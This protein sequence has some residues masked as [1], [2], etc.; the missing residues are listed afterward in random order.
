MAGPIN[1]TSV[2]AYTGTILVCLAVLVWV[3][4]L[5]RAD[6]GVPFSFEDDAP[7]FAMLTKGLIDNGWVLHNPFVGMPTGLDLHDFPLTDTVHFV[8]LK[9]IAAGARQFATTLNLY[10]VLTFPLTAVA[11]LAA[12]RSFDV[13]FGPAIVGSLLFA[14]LPYHLIRGEIHIF[15]SAYYLVPLMTMVILW[16]CLGEPLSVGGRAGGDGRRVP[17]RRRAMAGLAICALLASA[18]V[19]YAFFGAAL[20]L[21]GGAFAA[22][23]RRR[24]RLFLPAGVLAGIILLVSVI[25]LAPTL[26]Y[27]SR[28][29]TNPVVARREPE[30][31]ELYGLRIAQLLL[32]ITGHREPHL[33]ALKE[34]YNRR[35]RHVQE[36]ENDSPALGTIGGIGFLLLLWGLLGGP[37]HD[38]RRELFT[39]LGALTISAVLLA[40]TSGFGSL[41]AFLVTP[42]IRAY[43]RMSV[44]IAF[45]SLFAVVI[46]LDRLGRRCSRSRAGRCLFHASLALIVVMGILDQ[47]G[48]GSVPPYRRLKAEFARDADFIG[49]IEAAVPEGAM[50][51]QLPYMAFPEAPPE[52][53]M[54]GYSHL[55]AYLHSKTLR[56]SYGAM[57]GRRGDLWQRVL[58]AEPPGELADTLALG[59]FRGIYVDREGYPDR[60]TALEGELAKRAGGRA[61]VSTDGRLAFF[62][63]APVARRLRERYAGEEWQRRRDAVLHPLLLQWAGGCSELEGTPGNDWRWCSRSGELRVYN[64]SARAQRAA[65]EMSLATGYATLSHVWIESPWFSERLD[66]NAAGTFF[67]K[68]IT[69]PP[70]RSVIRFR[71][72]ARELDAPPDPRSLVFRIVN[73]RFIRPESPQG[74]G[75]GARDTAR[76]D[77][78]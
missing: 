45:L 46:W 27:I 35:S 64:P 20:L 54:A 71:S 4:R 32:P 60:G 26:L 70:G 69:V 53:R 10:Y 21:V 36:H 22:G 17:V 30:E 62:D 6:W 67:S 37:P 73:F 47:T 25:N 7:F 39:A 51:F 38:P 44:Y 11:A 28:N 34:A 66:V 72:D 1:R 5:W 2:A 8:A 68:A 31:S 13:A 57:K 3:L 40:T 16:V 75:G 50:I 14:F 65:L 61:I 74:G 42:E 41:L 23:R 48:R 24:P 77:G 76:R 63:L 52:H 12:F 55:R 33:R 78:A 18:G 19:Y 9:L 29:G 59:G 49:R 15:L 43:T 56:W 58:A